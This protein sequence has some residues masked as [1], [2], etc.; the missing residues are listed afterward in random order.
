M[1]EAIRNVTTERAVLPTAGVAYIHD[2][3]MTVE[4]EP[5]TVTAPLYQRKAVADFVGPDLIEAQVFELSQHT[6]GDIAFLAGQAG[7]ADQ[8][9][10]EL[11]GLLE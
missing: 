6:R 1:Q 11:D 4:H 9:L 7:D 3:Q 10:R 2:I 8:G 5:M